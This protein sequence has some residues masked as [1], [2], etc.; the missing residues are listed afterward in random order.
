MP[1]EI[2][3]VD[4]LGDDDDGAGHF[5]IEAREQGA[6]NQS[7]TAVHLKSDEAPDTLSGSSM[8]SMQINDVTAPV[9]KLT[10]S[11]RQRRNPARRRCLT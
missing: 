10:S 11:M 8:V 6:P 4:A 9:H 1:D 7:F 5:V 2:V 3:G